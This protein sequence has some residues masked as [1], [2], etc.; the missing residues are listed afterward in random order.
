MKIT[1]ESKYYALQTN[2]IYNV[3]T[4]QGDFCTNMGP[5]LMSGNYGLLLELFITPEENSNTRIRKFITFD[6]SEMLGNPYSFVINSRQSKQIA[7][8]SEG[9]VTEV[10]L[11][12]YQGKNFSV[13][14]GALVEED[15][16]FL[17]YQG[18]RIASNKNITFSKICPKSLL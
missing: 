9:I 5:S 4:L 12:I 8:A 2:G 1:P 7:I 17:D 6:S 13:S 18:N 14:N 16:P 10:I 15:N 11:S 3:I